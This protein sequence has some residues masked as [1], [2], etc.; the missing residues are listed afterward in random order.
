MDPVEQLGAEPQAEVGLTG[1]VAGVGGA[2][3][4]EGGSASN[5]RDR[6]SDRRSALPAEGVHDSVRRIIRRRADAHHQENKPP[7]V[8]SPHHAPGTADKMLRRIRSPFG[9]SKTV[10]TGYFMIDYD[11]TPDHIG[12]YFKD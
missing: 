4:V 6:E 7:H 8:P 3:D 10:L 9:R 5:S 11:F 1:E 12:Y 2:V